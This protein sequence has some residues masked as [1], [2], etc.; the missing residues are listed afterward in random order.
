MPAGRSPRLGC[1]LVLP[2]DVGTD[3]AAF[4]YLQASG[5]G[6][7][8][9]RRVVERRAAGAAWSPSAC[10]RRQPPPSL[11]KRRQGLFEPGPVFRAEVNFVARSI[12]AE[13]DRLGVAR[14]VQIVT[15]YYR[16]LRHHDD[17]RL[18][19]AESMSNQRAALATSQAPRQ[20]R[21]DTS[22]RPWL[23]IPEPDCA[24]PR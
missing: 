21:Q 15:D 12:K 16:H 4:G 5:L 9:N 17:D 23:A 10:A 24:A 19:S 14:A 8:P 20:P 18:V 11:D 7:C 2:D 1:C 6:P 13:T 3:P 22:R